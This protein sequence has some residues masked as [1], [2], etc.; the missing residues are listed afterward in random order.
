MW[1]KIGL[2]AGAI[3]AGL[4]GIGFFLPVKTQVQQSIAVNA[5]PQLVFDTLSNI[6]EFNAWSPWV[7][8]APDAT[9][10]YSGPDAGEGASM[11]WE[12]KKAGSGTMT[13]LSATP[14]R[15]DVALQFGGNSNAKSWYDLSLRGDATLVTW[16]FETS[17][18]GLALWDRYFG[19]LLIAPAIKK[20]YK[21]G[22]ADFKTYIETKATMPQAPASAPQA[23]AEP[24]TG[25]PP[26]AVAGET[27][28]LASRP[29]ILA[30]GDAAG[31]GI[32]AAVAAAYAKADAFI[33]AQ[34]LHPS[35]MAIAITR[36]Y[37]VAT[38]HWVFDAGVPVAAAPSKTP[39]AADGVTVGQTYAG[40]AVKFK[41]HGRPDGTEPTYRAIDAWMKS[42]KFVPNGDS[43]EEYL[44]DDKTPKDDWDI[45][46]YFPV[47]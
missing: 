23:A 37:D 40:K 21:A 12:S 8:R 47:K 5:P 38:G 33:S 1:R 28:T 27:V 10:K 9:F 3:V 26:V 25:E 19:V 24:V 44:S 32:D 7:K 11:S 2:I 16:G 31:S 29:V 46:I 41:Y 17:P 15:I 36:G 20:D 4:A 34:K 22:L 13:I 14:A 30:A 42:K 18:Y 45:N 35:G 39:A 6:K 43:W